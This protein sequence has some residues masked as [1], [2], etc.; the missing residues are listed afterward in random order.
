MQVIPRLRKPIGLM[1]TNPLRISWSGDALICAADRLRHMTRPNVGAH[2]VNPRH[3]AL[4]H[5]ARASHPSKGCYT[6]GGS[7]S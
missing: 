7:L 5:S 1:S 3:S 2:Q 6:F 4:L